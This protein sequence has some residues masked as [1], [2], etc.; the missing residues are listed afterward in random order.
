MIFECSKPFK[1]S[2]ASVY[3][4]SD[5]EVGL[6]GMKKTQMLQVGSSVELEVMSPFPWA[7]WTHEGHLKDWI[8][9]QSLKY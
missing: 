3:A 9:T 5:V 6:M 7:Q 2:L 4:A 8:H 1:C